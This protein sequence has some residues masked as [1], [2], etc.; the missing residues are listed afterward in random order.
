MIWIIIIGLLAIGLGVFCFLKFHD[1]E[2]YICF[3]LAGLTLAF[4]GLLLFHKYDEVERT[5]PYK[6]VVSEN[7]HYVGHD[8]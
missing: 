7:V 5:E 3:I 4:M 2:I 6:I 8:T 1:M